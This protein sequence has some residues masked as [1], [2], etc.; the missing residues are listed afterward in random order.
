M[1]ICLCEGQIIS[2]PHR[3]PYKI[4]TDF[5]VR[6]YYLY[7][8]KTIYNAS[9]CSER[10]IEQVSRRHIQNIYWC[11]S[12]GLVGMRSSEHPRG[13][14]LI[15]PIKVLHMNKIP[16]RFIPI[17]T[18]LNMCLDN[19]CRSVLFALIQLSSFFA[20]DNGWFF[21][22][23]ADLEAE[24]NL[25]RD[26]AKGALYALFLE[27]IIE[28][29]PQE[30]G[31]GV[32]QESRKYKVNFDKFLEYEKM[33]VDDCMKNPEYR[34]ETADYKHTAITFQRTSQPTSIQ[35]SELP[36]QPTSLQS[37]NNIENID[38]RENIDNKETIYNID[39]IIVK[40]NGNS[41]PD[42]HI[43]SVEGVYGSP[44]DNTA[45][46]GSCSFT[47]AIPI[48]SSEPDGNRTTSY[49]LPTCSFS[50]S[51]SIPS[52]TYSPEGESSNPEEMKQQIIPR[53]KEICSQQPSDTNASEG[54]VS[55][56]FP[57]QLKDGDSC[58]TLKY[59]EEV[60]EKLRAAHEVLYEYDSKHLPF[61]SVS[62]QAFRDAVSLCGQYFGYDYNRAKAWVMKVRKDAVIQEK[63]QPHEPE[64]TPE[65]EPLTEEMRALRDKMFVDV[66]ALEADDDFGHAW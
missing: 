14:F 53:E 28:V 38:S 44:T 9:L 13:C 15:I 24:T 20:D 60:W 5:L 11:Q 45:I 21:R 59:S 50:S 4:L 63:E 42:G 26:V 64:P 54:T 39:N 55:V 12:L 7:G 30:K 40:P 2:W 37:C 31:R 35:T 66:D 62:G 23:N 32:K 47:D 29:I 3:I 61:D 33:S 49:T 56:S 27:G 57:S 46:D 19:N 43:S 48:Y 52:T 41:I 1:Y 16:Y 18:H 17:P 34:I 36:S 8:S 25:S 10:N 6:I 22:T 51:D 65:P 58:A